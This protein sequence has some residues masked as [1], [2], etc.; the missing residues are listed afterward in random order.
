MLAIFG[1]AF[2]FSAGFLQGSFYLPMTYTRKWEWEH[3]WSIFSLSGMIVFSWIF[4]ILTVPNILTVYNSASSKEIIILIIFGGLWGIGGV[5][6]GLAMHK[7]G[8][9]LA[10]PI[11]MGIVSSF[12]ALIPLIVFFPATLFTAK[13]L[14]LITGTAVTIIGIIICSKA[15][16]LKEPPVET[17]TDT[18]SGSLTTK[19][20]IAVSAGIMSSLLNIAFAYSAGIVEIARKT[21][22]SETF[23]MNASWAIILTSGGIVN[24]L[25]CLYL[26]VTRNTAKQFFGPET[27]RNT[28]LGLLMGLLWCV[29]LYLYGFGASNLGSFGIVVGWVLFVSTIIIV[30]NLWGIWRGEWKGAPPQARGLLNRG[31]SILI[32]SIIIVAVS[33]SL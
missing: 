8:M 21:G 5:L 19:L 30:G 18:S 22:A 20:A 33:N 2:I 32:L 27:I 3:T 23:A 13:G 10:F 29:G 7:L 6:N 1:L 16:S 25:Y 26:M 12:G 4:I 15:F 11:V 24:I 28:G 9:A 17:T 14:V 31:I